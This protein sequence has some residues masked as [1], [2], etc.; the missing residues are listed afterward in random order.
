MAPATVP[1][2]VTSSPRLN[3]LL[4]PDTIKS[5]KPSNSFVTAMFTQSLGV[6]STS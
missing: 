2:Y 1:E 5:G 3:P 4:M 6:P